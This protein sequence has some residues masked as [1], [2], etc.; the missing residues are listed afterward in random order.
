MDASTLDG[1]RIVLDPVGQAGVALALF[2]IMLGVALGLKRSDFRFLR[3]NPLLFL[4]GV[5][6]QV[7]GLPLATFLVVLAIAPPPSIALGM[8]VVASCP[9]GSSS[10][11]LTFLSRGNVAYSVS[12]TATSS[13][14]AAFLTPVS[15]LFWSN[16]YA[17]TAAL[18][19]AIDFSPAAFLIQTSLLLA[20]PLGLGM[21]LAA[22]APRF[23]ERS[24][25]AVAL[26]G[27]LMLGGVIVY[28]TIYFFPTL[29]PALPLIAPIAILH[30]GAAF[31]VGAL[32][33]RLM[34]ADIPTRRALTFEVGIQNSGLALVILLS[35]L[36]GLGGATAIAAVWGV[37]HLIA[38][39]L[40]VALFR[41]LDGRKSA[42]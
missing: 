3:E 8:L 16:L 36:Q 9:G 5:S 17:P 23:A 13:L 1:L 28:G 34:R 11:L 33:G 21:G 38:G 30:N 32:G 18:L 40:I 24:R 12:L 31:A 2:L 7:I 15:I 14:I 22:T 37:W 10:N 42:Q 19:H 39:G 35:E 41:G 29:G 20:V 25:K 4:G 26:V 6:A 27:A